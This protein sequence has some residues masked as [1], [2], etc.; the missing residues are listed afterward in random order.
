[1]L[2]EL[3]GDRQYGVNATLQARI[4]RGVPRRI[5]VITYDAPVFVG[6]DRYHRRL[7]G[8]RLVALL[9]HP[10]QPPR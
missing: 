9:R 8:Q 4:S 6:R 2:T 5:D 10:D 3:I 7:R 1:M